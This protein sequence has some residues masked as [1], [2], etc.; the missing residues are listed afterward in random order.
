MMMNAFFSGNGA[1]GVSG[2]F[3]TV[4]IAESTTGKVNPLRSLNMEALCKDQRQ[5]VITPASKK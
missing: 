4:T 2:L 1:Y 5:N 3:Y